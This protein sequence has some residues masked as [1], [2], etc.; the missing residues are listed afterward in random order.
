MADPRFFRRSGPFRLQELAEHAGA[1]LL[2][3]AA[4]EMLIHDV[5]PL[6]RAGP[7]D[8]TFFDNPA[9]LGQYRETGAAACVTA[10]KHAGK[11]PPGTALL[12][13]PAPYGAYARIAQL[14]YPPPPVMPGRHPSA[15]VH[16]TALIGEGAW[17]GPCAVIEAGVRIGAGSSIGAGTVI[18]ENAEVGADCRIAPNCTLSHCIIGDRVTL[19]PGVRI[20]QDGFGFHPDP[21]GHVKVPQLGR[22][23]IGDGCEIGANTTIDRGAGPDTVVGAGT[24]IDNL[25]Q[26]G[27]N[28]ETGQGCILVAQCGLSGSTKLGNFVAIAAQSGVAGHLTV[29]DGARLAARSGSMH[30]IPAGE[31]WGGT[32]AMPLK[33]YFRMLKTLEKLGEQKV[34]KG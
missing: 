10:E 27:H 25:V 21:R 1:R 9:Y 22:V 34:E 23:R 8:L 32:P 2:D 33:R 24:W 6:D 4:G 16:E 13:S 3:P 29:G 5:A 15:V 28:A 11:A 7:E 17:I 18:G 12:I 31:T 26:I 14:F 19:H 20:G 30:S